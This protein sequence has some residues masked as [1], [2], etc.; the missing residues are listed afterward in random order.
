M[1]QVSQTA[2]KQ[3][4]REQKKSKPLARSLQEDYS[5][6]EEK[7]DENMQDSEEE[8]SSN[9]QYSRYKSKHKTDRQDSQSVTTQRR[10]WQKQNDSIDRMK[11][12][13]PVR[14]GGFKSPLT[15][16]PQ[17]IQETPNE[18][19]EDDS[20]EENL[21]QHAREIA[22]LKGQIAENDYKTETV[23]RQ[24]AYLLHKNS[25]REEEAGM[26]ATIFGWPKEAT[27]ED[28]KLNARWLID[29]SGVKD[30]NLTM[31][32]SDKK[33]R[34][35]NYAR[36][37][38]SNQG[39][40]DQ[41]TYHWYEHIHKLHNTL[42]YYDPHHRRSTND[43]LIVRAQFSQERM[44]RSAFIKAGKEVLK[45]FG[46]EE[47]TWMNA[48]AC[49]ISDDKGLLL[50]IVFRHFT[51]SAVV[52]ADKTV[53]QPIHD[54]FEESLWRI[55][56]NRT[57]KGKG[58]EEQR[59]AEGKGKEKGKTKDSKGKVGRAAFDF[60][61]DYRRP[62][63]I[64]YVKVDNWETHKDIEYEEDYIKTVEE[65]LWEEAGMETEE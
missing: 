40:R 26:L 62:F 16:K 65:K 21:R 61:F 17:T 19:K 44:M 7:K 51:A 36:L 43:K 20:I 23:Q 25:K 46:L 31:T 63:Y 37:R 13:T 24:T 50:W 5:G 2:T 45:A 59:P 14:Q 9:S 4:Q 49:T 29:Q 54:H 64:K 39:L 33:G 27:L 52:F 10:I 35:S 53:F 6:S 47:N 60:N 58:G 12:A 28:R 11:T 41:F 48:D 56:N 42:R 38:F 1:R 30:E 34:L 18:E 3:K 15:K 32:F 22:N 55:R 57:G 8:S